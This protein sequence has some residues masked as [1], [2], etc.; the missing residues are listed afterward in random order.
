[1]KKYLSLFCMLFV[2]SLIA[3]GENTDTKKVRVAG[4][5]RG[6]AETFLNTYREAL[7][8]SANENDADL[9][10]YFCNNDSA[11]QLDQVKNLLTNGVKYFVI[12][13]VDTALTEQIVRLIHSMGGSVAFSN[14][15]PS[16]AALDIDKNV[17]HVS[18]AETAAGDFQAQILDD[19]FKNNPRKLSGKTIKI[20]YLNGEVGHSTQIFRK[21]GF[22][23]GLTKR[24]YSVDI[25]AEGSATWDFAI[26]RQ[27]TD[28]WIKKNA[29]FD[30]IVAQN[31]DMALGAVEALIANGRTDIPGDANKDS[32]GDG[33]ALTVPV[34]G[35]DATDAAKTSIA[36]HK[37]YATVLQDAA[38][39]AATAM[40][41]IVHCARYG[42][43]KG[44]E[45]KAG[46]KALDTVTQE[47]PA[48]R[49]S[50]L[51]QCFMV[52]FVPITK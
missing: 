25:V 40:E 14:I 7:V 52:P 2:A 4:L 20:L 49:A 5:I 37:L 34:I 44:F 27:L 11:V 43:A 41:V 19:Y 45:T 1:M 10:I 6:D 16:D 42:S 13:P 22:M 32:D 12:I 48:T 15:L 38:G 28:N 31:D 30:A 35:V 36:A 33:T 21:Q 24:G 51:D 47:S 46:I 18:S 23:D 50:V 17:F 8:K 3:C 29:E 39:Q 26:A 9:Q